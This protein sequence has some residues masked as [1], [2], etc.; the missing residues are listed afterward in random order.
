MTGARAV[1]FALAGGQS[2]RM[3]RDK[4]L[5]PW[6]QATLLDHTLTRLRECCDDIRIL[7]G[8]T[9]RY[10]DRGAPVDVDIVAGVGA[11]AG[12]LTGLEWLEDRSGL[13]LAT[14]LPWVPAALLMELLEL[15]E[16]YD[17]VVPVSPEGLQPLA[18]VYR[19]TC[20]AAIRRCLDRGD[21]RVTSFLSRVKVREVVRE[22]LAAFGDPATMFQ[23][24]NTAE[25]YAA[26]RQH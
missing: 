15:A 7:C 13:F 22:E 24:L 9:P 18:A 16:T 19:G 3:G 5:L 4:A 6:G 26:A 10:L 17:A 2:L 1:G 11:L 25:D 12:V 14:D 20:R 8:P 23:N 21:Y